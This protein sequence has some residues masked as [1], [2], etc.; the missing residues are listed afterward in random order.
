MYGGFARRG[1]GGKNRPERTPVA[2]SGINASYAYCIVI[3]VTFRNA[4]ALAQQAQREQGLAAAARGN[5]ASPP[6]G[7]H[8]M[9][10]SNGAARLLVVAA[11][12]CAAAA[13][14]G[15]ADAPKY[16]PRGK[17]AALLTALFYHDANFSPAQSRVAPE[18]A[19]F[20]S[21]SPERALAGRER[22]KVVDFAKSLVYEGGYYPREIYA[23]LGIRDERTARTGRLVRQL[24]GRSGAPSPWEVAGRVGR[25]GMSGSSDHWAMAAG[26]GGAGLSTPGTLAYLPALAVVYSAYPED[27]C[28]AAAQLAVLKDDDMRAAPA[29]RAAAGLLIRV[30]TADAH[31]KDG[32]LR[33]AGRDSGDGDTE[34][35]LRAVRVKEWRYLRGEECAMGR[36]ERAAYIWYKGRDYAGVMEEGAELLRSRESLAYLAALAA[37]TYGQEALPGRVINSGAADRQLLELVNDLYDLATSE[38]VLQVA[39]PDEE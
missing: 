17:V 18:V 37:A 33:G 25:S 28:E 15:A 23:L 3:V 2:Q 10:K 24:D 26:D 20:V 11:V 36:L 12:L 16:P 39:P 29:A 38:A 4:V 32:W 22:G 14:G 34:H 1:G 8:F 19:A 35:D 9:R 5:A 21:V 6:P 31:D 27:G 13:R 30:L 7:V